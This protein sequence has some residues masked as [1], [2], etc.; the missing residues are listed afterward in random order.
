MA[1]GLLPWLP[2]WEADTSGLWA[3]RTHSALCRSLTG[4]STC[5]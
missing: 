3:C 2:L 1:E 5:M 4:L